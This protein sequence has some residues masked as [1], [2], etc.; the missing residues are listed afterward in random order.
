MLNFSPDER[1]AGSSDP[2]YQVLVDKVAKFNALWP[3]RQELILNYITCDGYEIKNHI[4]P[5]REY[6]VTRAIL[7]LQESDEVKEQIY[8]V[9]FLTNASVKAMMQRLIVLRPTDDK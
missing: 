7:R 2:G 4:F 9:L 5:E 3:A 8:R 6:W 1:E